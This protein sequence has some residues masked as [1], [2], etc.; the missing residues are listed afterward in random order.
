MSGRTCYTFVAAAIG[1]AAP[2][3]YQ[4]MAA[5][6]LPNTPIN[7]NTPAD[8]PIKDQLKGRKR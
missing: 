7:L 6:D 1:G 3:E 4:T 2:S 8:A 5:A